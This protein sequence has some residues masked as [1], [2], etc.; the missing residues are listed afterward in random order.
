MRRYH[1]ATGKVEDICVL[2]DPDAIPD[3]LKPATNGDLYI[4]T[5]LTGGVSVIGADGTDKGLLKGFGDYV[6]NVQFRGSTLYVTDI[7]GGTGDDA[8]FH[9][10]ISR[11]KLDGVMGLELFQG[12]SA[13]QGK[14][15]GQVRS[16]VHLAVTA[17]GDGARRRGVSANGG[18]RD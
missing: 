18:H 13:R 1:V 11:A 16:R 8:E 17:P 4:G 9:G 5:V 6:S 7:G 12:R 3:G 14:E 10:S 15:G 2:E